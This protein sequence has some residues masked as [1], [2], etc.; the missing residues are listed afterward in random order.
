MPLNYKN[1][2][3]SNVCPITYKNKSNKS[4]HK[5]GLSLY[6]QPMTLNTIINK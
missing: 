1:K 6:H 5:Q 2:S 4:S 3:E